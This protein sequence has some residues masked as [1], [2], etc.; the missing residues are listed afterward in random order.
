M[1]ALAN[2]AMYGC[3]KVQRIDTH[4]ATVFLAGNSALKVKRT[5]KLPFLDYSTYG[6]FALGSAN[7]R[8][9]VR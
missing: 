6:D 3:A 2:P 1:A 7:A 5:V 4:A 8:A 9:L